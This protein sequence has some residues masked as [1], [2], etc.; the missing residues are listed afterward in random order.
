MGEDTE[1]EGEFDP[2]CVENIYEEINNH[3]F[4]LRAFGALLR[5]S[6]LM[7]FCNQSYGEGREGKAEDLRWGLG[8]IIDL[9]LAH[10]ERI[11][12]EYVDRYD[13]SDM[14]LVG[15]ARITLNMIGQRAYRTREAAATNLREAASC[16]DI[17]IGRGGELKCQAEELKGKCMELLNAATGK[18]ASNAKSL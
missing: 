8:Q 17:V 4:A 15:R 14:A 13:K 6:D 12:S 10:Q 11:L 1:R 2:G 5:S 18:E 3:N 7:D 9:Y 16:L